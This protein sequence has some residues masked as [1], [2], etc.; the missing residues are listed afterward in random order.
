MGTAIRQINTG[1][2][3]ISNSIE[4]LS[5]QIRNSNDPA[6]IQSLVVDLRAAVQERYRLQ[7]EMLQKQLDAEELTINQYN[8][9]L[10]SINRAE[11]T[12]LI[13]ADRLASAEISDLRS[14]ANALIQNA[15]ERGEYLLGSVTSDTDFEN[16]RTQLLNL[17]NQYYDNE[18][19]RINGLVASETELQDLREDN[20]LARAQALERIGGIE[21]KFVQDRIRQEHQLA[22]IRT[23]F[24][25]SHSAGELGFQRS[26][27]DLFREIGFG[28]S[29]F[30]I[31]R[32]LS[33]SLRTEIDLQGTDDFTRNLESNISEL[34]SDSRFSLAADDIDA[35][36]DLAL[37]FA[38]QTADRKIDEQIALQEATLIAER[39]LM[40][41]IDTNTLAIESLTTAL[42]SEAFPI[43]D[44]PILPPAQSDYFGAGF[45]SARQDQSETGGDSDRPIVI[46][47]NSPVQ[48][49]GE[50]IG[51]I[52][53]EILVKRDKA[54]LTQGSYTQGG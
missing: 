25:R 12:A 22:D 36:E 54:G 17:T 35:L 19:E 29:S 51:R 47:I 43:P 49:D 4:E 23:R 34:L 33:E 10:G 16:I 39:A 6:E 5:D 27:E 45:A 50:E 38:R 53:D 15:I 46:Q 24:Q 21:N 8:A 40:T 14:D 9:E 13:G 52:F 26:I 30:D 7:R 42:G 41:S 44:V 31:G 48:I 18:L 28:D 20:V 32:R 2:D 3:L 37:G 11:S 1:A